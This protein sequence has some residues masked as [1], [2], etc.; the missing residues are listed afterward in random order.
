MEAVREF[1]GY[2]RLIEKFSSERYGHIIIGFIVEAFKVK[3]AD[4]E[5]VEKWI[6][7]WKLNIDEKMNDA[8]WMEAIVANR[9]GQH[10]KS[11]QLLQLMVENSEG[12]SPEALQ[13]TLKQIGDMNVN[14]MDQSK[15]MATIADEISEKQKPDSIDRD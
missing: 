11:V 1:E 2:P 12:V 15:I 14:I 6:E 3:V 9:Q 13:R 10:L 8:L 4:S 7:R 5:L